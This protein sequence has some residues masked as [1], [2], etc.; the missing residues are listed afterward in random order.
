MVG[1]IAYLQDKKLFF[2]TQ[3]KQL[4]YANRFSFLF[5]CQTTDMTD[6]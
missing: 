3:E 6:N 2:S 1:A 5:F 4:F